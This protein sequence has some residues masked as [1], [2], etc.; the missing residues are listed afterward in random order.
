MENN[1]LKALT[2]DGEP[3][4]INLA[5]ILSIRPKKNGSVSVLLGAGVWWDIKPDTMVYIDHADLI[6]EVMC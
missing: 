1:W 2:T 4:Y 3:V 6:G 5:N